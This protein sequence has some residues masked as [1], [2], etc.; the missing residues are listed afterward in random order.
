MLDSD[1]KATPEENDNHR[2]DKDRR[3]S[4]DRLQNNAEWQEE[5]RRNEEGRRS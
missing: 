1:L 4:T 2:S 3:T 5:E